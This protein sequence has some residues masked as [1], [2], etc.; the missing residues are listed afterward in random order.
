MRAGLIAVC[1]AA[2]LATACNP[3]KDYGNL[4]RLTKASAGGDGGVDYILKD[5]AAVKP[6]YDFLANGDPDCED[7]VCL[8]QAGKDYGTADGA[9]FAD[10][11][12]Y[13]HGECSTPCT[14]DADCGEP[15]RGLTCTKLG[16][17]QAF[18]DNLKRTDPATYNQYFGD[19]A[20]AYFCTDPGLPDVTK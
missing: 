4:C 2:L 18:L 17:D 8:R 12:L 20:S 19:V 9:P 16:F 7:L 6:G 1:G 13:A 11:K 3:P 15:A 14:A 5:D 10:G